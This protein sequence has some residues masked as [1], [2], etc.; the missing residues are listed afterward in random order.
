MKKILVIL[1]G[2]FVLLS[3][4]SLVKGCSLSA[5]F[6][7]SSVD[8]GVLSENS[9]NNSALNL[10]GIYNATIDTDC[11]YQISANG[12][13]F[14]DG[15]GHTFDIGNLTMDSDTSPINFTTQQGNV[16]TGAK[17]A[18][19]W[20]IANTSAW[21]QKDNLPSTICNL[22]VQ[23]YGGAGGPNTLVG[24]SIDGNY[25]GQIFFSGASAYYNSTTSSSCYA[26]TDGNFTFSLSGGR[27][28]SDTD[29]LG[30]FDSGQQVYADYY[31]FTYL[32]A[33]ISYDYSNIIPKVLSSSPQII[34]TYSSS[35]TDN[36]FGFWLSIPA[37]QYA[38]TYSSTVPITYANV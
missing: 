8:F 16:K 23:M 21:L 26:V 37:M 5:I 25:I 22:S 11:S 17:S 35:I 4:A 10:D 34:D 1:L 18:S 15:S 33:N 38:S 32:Y 20:H 30:D 6:N 13:V 3:F 14:D 29:S 7:F 24:V 19:V 9:I 28:L 27:A 2:M 31:G 12:T 36:F